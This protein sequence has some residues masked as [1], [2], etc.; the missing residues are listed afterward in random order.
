MAASDDIA[1]KLDELTASIKALAVK[2]DTALQVGSGLKFLVGTVLVGVLVPILNW[3]VQDA[4][5]KI[6][7]IESDREFVSKLADKALDPSIETR[8]RFSRYFSTQLGGKWEQYRADLEKELAEAKEQEAKIK[9]DQQTTQKKVETLNQ[10]IS[11]ADVPDPKKVAELEQHTA[12][13]R[14]IGRQIQTLKLDITP[15]EFRNAA[16]TAAP[17]LANSGWCYVGT[18]KAGAWLGQTMAVGARLPAPGDQLVVTTNVFLRDA[19]PSETG[20]LGKSLAA[21]LQGASLPVI[22]VYQR[23]DSGAV[24]I[25]TLVSRPDDLV[26]ADAAL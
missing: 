20:T 1:A 2:S 26:P 19:R 10:E 9:S 25:K 7:R 8:L 23:P 3:Q 18:L 24:W 4:Q 6:K 15:R 14:T 17:A 11:R 22:E 16:A 21:V 13:L 12:E 5:V